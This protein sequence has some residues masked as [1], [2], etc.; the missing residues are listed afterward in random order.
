MEKQESNIPFW[1]VMTA[2]FIGSFLAILGISTI[3]VAIPVL[4]EQFHAGLSTVQWTMTGFMLATG[5]VAP[6]TGYLGE[7][8]STKYLYMVALVG[9]TLMSGLCAFAWN[10]ESLIVFR[11][12]QG[13]FSGIVMPVTMTIIYQ[14]I[15]REK[16][17]FALSVWTLSTMLAPAF[18]P[19]LA[20][21][22]IEA[23]TWKWLFL[24]NVPFGIVSVLVAWRLIPYYKL[25]TPKIFDLLG[26]LTV[27]LSSGSLLVAIS[28]AHIWGWSSWRTLSLFAFGMAMLGC[29][30]RRELSVPEPLLNL[31]VLANRKFTI[32]LI[33][34]VVITISLYSGVY[35]TPVFLQNI[36]QASALDTGLILLPAS[37]A[38]AVS[39]PIIG[40]LYM[41]V[42]PQWLIAS[43]ISLI[44][45]GTLAMGRLDVN[46]SHGYIMLW[47]MVRNIGISLSIMPITN[48]GMEAIPK[49]LSGH[50]S[51]VN[52]WIRQVFGSFSIALF[53]S[54]LASRMTL[55]TEALGLDGAVEAQQKLLQA[56]AFTMSSN[57]VYMVAMLI[58]LAGLPFVWMLNDGKRR[59]T[60]QT[61]KRLKQSSL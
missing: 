36:Q 35:L 15:P 58:V 12:M 44:A 24:M 19:T 21:W 18:G 3:S 16:Q 17:P 60:A 61:N 20:G 30:I 33:V 8:F 51:S 1:P 22:L 56:E 45:I 13:I 14:V 29:F 54:L 40:K 2:I 10:V 5:V 39:M 26:M 46:I 27:V 9:F 34:A 37:L 57:D 23:F 38:M 42:S 7:R 25:R 31:K 28:E 53:T 52:N 48:L 4:M 50:A 11:I 6:V 49:E 59:K 41:R 43:G 32:S 47:M 55:H